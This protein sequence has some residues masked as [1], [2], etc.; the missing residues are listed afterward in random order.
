MYRERN[1]YKKRI[2]SILFKFVKKDAQT[3]PL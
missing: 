3:Q 2:F 1:L